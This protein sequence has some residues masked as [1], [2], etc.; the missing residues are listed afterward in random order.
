MTREATTQSKSKSSSASTEQAKT[1][2]VTIKPVPASIK[3]DIFGD[4]LKFSKKSTA[5]TS[6]RKFDQ[7][8]L[9][10]AQMN[11]DER[12]LLYKIFCGLGLTAHAR[13][14]TETVD[15]KKIFDLKNKL[16]LSIAN[17][18]NLRRMVNLRLGVSRR[19]KVT[20]YCADCTER[21]KA[22]NLPAREWKFC[23][24]CTIDR[25]YYNI[26]S[27]F[28][29]FE[30][31]SGALFL[32]QDLLPQIHAHQ[33]IKKVPLTQISEE[34]SF[35]KYK[36]SPKSLISIEFESLKA[37]TQKLIDL[38]LKPSGP[39]PVAKLDKPQPIKR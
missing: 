14:T 17:D 25:N 27:L 18:P 32:G 2:G 23:Q 4:L 33:Q 1:R 11:R 22:E 5:A 34:L 15:R 31:G 16:F 30:Q 3:I 13:R 39:T 20:A 24:K 8:A 7:L 10:L 37:C 21:N 19:F 36:F 6:Y 38:S 29:R 12:I 9:H 26:V 28:H 35:A